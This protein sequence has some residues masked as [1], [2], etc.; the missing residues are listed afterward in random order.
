MRAMVSHPTAPTARNNKDSLRPKIT[1]KNMTKKISG[2][3]LK[4]SMP[5]IIA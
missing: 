4:I 3:P 2:S 5:R 1:V